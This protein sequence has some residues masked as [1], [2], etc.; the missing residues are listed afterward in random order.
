MLK[1]LGI[2]S[3]GTFGILCA[4]QDKNSLSGMYVAVCS[5]ACTEQY[6]KG[7]YSTQE[8]S[9]LVL[10]STKN[11]RCISRG[12]WGVDD[13]TKH[14]NINRDFA[15]VFTSVIQSFQSSISPEYTRFQGFFGNFMIVCCTLAP[16]FFVFSIPCRSVR[17]SLRIFK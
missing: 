16:G 1:N 9:I 7:C 13:V 3:T 14:T 10:V 17:I 11:N 4:H 8:K 6:V 12:C 2:S 15:E 5:A